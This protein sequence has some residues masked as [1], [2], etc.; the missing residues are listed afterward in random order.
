MFLSHQLN[1][2]GMKK[3]R[4]NYNYLKITTEKHGQNALGAGGRVFESLHP[5]LKTK[6]VENQRVM[7][8][9]SAFFNRFR[10]LFQRL[11]GQR[12]GTKLYQIVPNV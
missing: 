7:L 2:I 11:G 9:V 3:Y 10:H 8:V 5:D 4:E 12:F 1:R 6:G